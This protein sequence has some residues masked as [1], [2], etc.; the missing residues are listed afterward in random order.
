V[1]KKNRGYGAEKKGMVKKSGTGI[2]IKGEEVWGGYNLPEVC[3]LEERVERGGEGGG[4]NY[5]VETREENQVMGKP[6]SKK[7]MKRGDRG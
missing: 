7:S 2:V 1:G 3:H 5:H 4:K 6:R